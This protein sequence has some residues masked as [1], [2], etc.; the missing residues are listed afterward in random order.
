MQASF[1]STEKSSFTVREI[2]YSVPQ[3][4]CRSI[5]LRIRDF[6]AGTNFCDCERLVISGDVQYFCDFQEEA[7]KYTILQRTLSV[8]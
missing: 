1:P 6:F 3:N 8:D 4:F 5:I 2:S 7:F